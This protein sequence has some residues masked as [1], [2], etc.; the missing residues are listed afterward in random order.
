VG[1][2]TIGEIVKFVEGTGD[3]LLHGLEGAIGGSPFTLLS[4]VGHAITSLLGS[5]TVGE[6]TSFVSVGVAGAELSSAMSAHASSDVVASG[7]TIAFGAASPESFMPQ[8][9]I[10]GSY[11]D[12]GIA[13]QATSTDTHVASIDHPDGAVIDGGHSF[14][15]HD[16]ASAASVHL[17][18]D[19]SLR[20]SM[21]LLG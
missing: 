4:D 7:G 5:S 16:T 6:S 12:F 9:T 17:H 13:V 3:G 21:D 1:S 20:T 11:T 14:D 18:D 8:L 2:G 15:Q 19:T 10:N